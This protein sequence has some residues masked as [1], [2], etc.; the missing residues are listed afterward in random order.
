MSIAAYPLQW[1]L[2]WRRTPSSSRQQ[3]RFTRSRQTTAQAGRYIPARSITLP[4]AIER[5]LRELQRMRVASL[6]DVV[7]ST[8]RRTRLDGRPRADEAEPA[9]PGVAVYWREAGEGPARVM[10]I[11]CY[12]TVAGNLGAVAATL[13]AMRAIERHGGAVI[14]ERAFTGFLALP[15]PAAPGEK[16]AW[17]A[18]LGVLPDGSIEDA[19]KAWRRLLSEHH[20]DRGGGD[21]ARA[22]EIN[23]AWA[24]A[25]EAIG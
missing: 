15:A 24:E 23:E 16:R 21:P 4:E 8:N 6:E 9:D 12:D 25:Q 1:P 20:P 3:A 13:E 19:R 5:V 14:L 2:G 22:A 17:R 7:L 11:D 18:V 10:A